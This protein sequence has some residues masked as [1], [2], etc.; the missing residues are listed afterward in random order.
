MAATEMIAKLPGTAQDLKELT[1]IGKVIEQWSYSANDINEA[2]KNVQQDLQQNF[3][4]QYVSKTGKEPSIK[5]WLNKMDTTSLMLQQ[6]YITQNPFPL[7]KKFEL[8]HAKADDEIDQPFWNSYDKTHEKLQKRMMPNVEAFGFYDV[9]LITPEG[10]IVYS[11]FKETDYGTSLLMG[12]WANT[13]LARVWKEARD[14]NM[15]NWFADYAHY[16]P[17]Y[18]D[19]AS[20]LVLP[21]VDGE[22]TLGHIAF[23]IGINQ[24]SSIMS[25]AAGLGETGEVL[26]VGNDYLMR[27]DSRL[28]PATHSLAASWAN[29]ETGKFDYAPMRKLHETGAS[30]FDVMVDYRKQETLTTYTPIA[31]WNVV[32]GLIAKEDLEELYRPISELQ[33]MLSLA[34]ISMVFFVIIASVVFSKRLTNPI[35]QLMTIMNASRITGN[36]GLR[37]AVNAHDEIG[38]MTQSFNELM[39][40]QHSMIKELDETLGAISQGNFN[41]VITSEYKGNLNH[42]K[43]RTND[44]V[45]TLRSTMGQIRQAVDALNSGS[46]NFK[47]DTS[48]LTGDFKSIMISLGRAMQQVNHAFSTIS[49]VMKELSVFN[50]NQRLEVNATGDIAELQN[51]INHTLLALQTGIHSASVTIARIEKGDFSTQMT[52]ELTGEMAQ[53]KTALNTA[54]EKINLTLGAITG[55]VHETNQNSQR[56]TDIALR[57]S[58]Q[59][60]AQSQALQSSAAAVEELSGQAQATANTATEASEQARKASDQVASGVD[61]M[62]QSMT[63]MQDIRR[64]SRRITEILSLIDSIA[65][66]TN[67]LALNAAVEAARA[68]DHG[69][70]F[71]VVAGEV[72][73]LS[74]KTVQAAADIK[75]LIENNNAQINKGADLIADAGNTMQVINNQITGFITL[76]DDILTKNL[77]QATAV[78]LSNQALQQID[79][80]NQNNTQQ[81]ANVS[82][83][84]RKMQRS[85]QYLSDMVEQFK[86]DTHAVSVANDLAIIASRNK[87][88]NK[89]QVVILDDHEQT[90][91]PIAKKALPALPAPTGNK[92]PK[93]EEWEEF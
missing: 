75:E 84:A 6:R 48:E 74:Q 22:K 16:S 4:A 69:R 24:I 10:R 23:Q 54:I 72:R 7:G 53:F 33:N 37:A 86:L 30:G 49:H 3:R 19:P 59:M 26:L 89:A 82:E 77:E 31:L 25:Q 80:L 71:A 46:F 60:L 79:H 50:L 65:F 13:N 73:A 29:P 11:Y 92:K 28:K 8:F 81:I 44:T 64:S 58:D 40:T 90:H 35:H 66:Q 55:R 17:S 39:Q 20:F 34:I 91:E 78:E 15:P 36:L 18:E 27:S 62:N 67:L 61:I 63:A 9:F 56:I 5:A 93:T 68:G 21:I 38:D 85:T 2:R 83:E 43:Q 45:D 12:P 1:S 70:G 32:W 47:A 76:L 88:G 57:V 41:Q 42:L 52:E 51:N 87:E 14:M